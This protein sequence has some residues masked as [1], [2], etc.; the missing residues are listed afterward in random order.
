MPRR[1]A[2]KIREI[3][4]RQG[5]RGLVRTFRQDIPEGFLQN[6][7]WQYG[8]TAASS[9]VHFLYTLLAVV[10][11]SGAAFKLLAGTAVALYGAAF[12][13]APWAIA[14]CLG[15]RAGVIFPSPAAR[16]ISPL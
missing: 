5:W 8:G 12:F 1:H 13:A 6:V 14:I 10:E 15:W 4:V 11:V 2:A 7:V 9:A 16:P 3:I